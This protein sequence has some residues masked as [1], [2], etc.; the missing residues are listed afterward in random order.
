MQVQRPT[1]W[2]IDLRTD[3]VIRRFEIPASIVSEGRGLASITPD[4]DKG[5]DRT[6][7]YIPDLVNNQLYV[8]RFVITDLIFDLH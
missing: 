2:I 8:Y 3:K 1:I 7:A 5:C 6:F 4:T